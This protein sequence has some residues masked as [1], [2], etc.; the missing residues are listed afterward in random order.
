MFLIRFVF[1]FTLSFAILCIPVGDNQHLFD[2][3]LTMVSPYANEAIKTTKRKIS[4]TKKYSKKLYSNSE[5][6]ENDEVKTNASATK[7][8]IHVKDA[9]AE[10]TYTEEEQ[11]RLQ[12][13]LNQNE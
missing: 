10:E 13:I 7:R 1:Y 5:P 12:K 9:D 2:K 3:L 8:K 4:S 11:A 6:I